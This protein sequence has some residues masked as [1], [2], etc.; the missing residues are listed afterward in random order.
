MLAVIY[1][2]IAQNVI[3]VI[4][5][6]THWDVRSVIDQKIA[7]I[8][9]TVLNVICVIIVKN[10]KIAQVVW[11]ATVAQIKNIKK[12]WLIIYNIKMNKKHMKL[13]LKNSEVKYYIFCT[14]L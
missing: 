3:F 9:K 11:I 10:V 1:A 2:F 4:I 12:I 5:V 8:V 13:I 7:V 6:L 14:Q